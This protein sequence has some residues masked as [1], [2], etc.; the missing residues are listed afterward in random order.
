MDAPGIRV[1]GEVEM[2]S[3]DQRGPWST[4]KLS[5]LGKYLRAYAV[6]MHSQRRQHQWPARIHYI[7]GF[8]G[9]GIALAPNGEHEDPARE[10]EVLAYLEGSPLKALYCVPPFDRL[11]FIELK[12]TRAVY[13][14]SLLRERNASD[15]SEVIIG[16]ANVKVAQ[17]IIDEV[18]ANEHGIAFLDP[19][20]LELR[21]ETVEALATARR[22]DVF[23][24]FSLMGIFR[25]LPRDAEPSLEARARLMAVLKDS[26]WMET[27]YVQQG[28]LDG[29]SIA[30]RGRIDPQRL[31]DRY[32]SDLKTV[33][34]FVSRPKIMTNSR[35][36]VLYALAFASH[37]ATATR[38]MEEI[39]NP[40]IGSRSRSA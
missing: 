35:G 6:I 20:G 33:F 32:A 7:D 8:A 31:A 14:R 4:E 19:Y 3:V 25:N 27:L 34:P 21:W 28:A 1:H 24:N 2:L 18:A 39:M 29:S 30:V 16:D 17:L 9:A 38:I 23:I 11:W 10:A 13:L 5:I 37:N 22:F 15:R 40:R 12:A 26:G 36:G